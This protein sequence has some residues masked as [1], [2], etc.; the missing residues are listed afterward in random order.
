MAIPTPIHPTSMSEEIT[1][2]ADPAANPS[3]GKPP[4]G[5]G[6]SGSR[7]KKSAMPAAEEFSLAALPPKA[8]KASFPVFDSPAKSSPPP[9]APAE[10]RPAK[11]DWPEPEAPTQGGSAGDSVH[12]KRK[13]N[14]RK[15]RGGAATKS[16][17]AAGEDVQTPVADTDASEPDAPS[18]PTQPSPPPAPRPGPRLKVDPEAL[19]KLAWKIYLSEVSEEGVALVSDNDAKELSRRCFRLAEIFMEE[20]ARRR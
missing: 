19:S 12:P 9:P 18:K 4:R 13:R 11:G 6:R 2:G 20:Q 14:R 7:P 3:E 15:G 17:A 16:A 10:D 5:R 1:S 8:T